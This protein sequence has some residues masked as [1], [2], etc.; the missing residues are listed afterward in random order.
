[1]YG[2]SVWFSADWAPNIVQGKGY[3]SEVEEGARIRSQVQLSLA[4]RMPMEHAVAEHRYGEL[5]LVQPRL[6]QGAGCLP[7]RR[8]PHT[9]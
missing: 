8:P 3:D 6:G 1:M 5:I 7:G 4:R 2:S 9:P